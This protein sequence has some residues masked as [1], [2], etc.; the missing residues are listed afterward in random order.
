MRPAA[1]PLTPEA[2][3]NNQYLRG[4]DPERLSPDGYTLDIAYMARPGAEEIQLD[5]ILDYRSNVALYPTFQAYFREHQP[6]LRAIWGKNDQSFIPPGAEAYRRD[7]PDAEVSF[8]DAGHFALETHAAEIA[9]AMRA[10]LEA[11]LRPAK[12]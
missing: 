10:F 9:Q 4:A 5:L 6:P 8:L 3:R 12:A 1:S 11:K 2:I 7:L